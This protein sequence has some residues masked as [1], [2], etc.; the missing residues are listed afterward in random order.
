M[1]YYDEN[2]SGDLRRI[3]EKEVMNWTNVT[4]KKMFGCPCY[5]VNKNLFALIVTNG[6]VITKLNE[7]EKNE[8]KQNNKTEYFQTGERIV[9]KWIKIPIVNYIEFEQILPFIKKSYNS[10]MNE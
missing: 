3:L 1:K 10:A 2:K 4:T 8:L 9:K 5:M 7:N 6:V